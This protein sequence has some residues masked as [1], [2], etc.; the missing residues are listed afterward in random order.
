MELTDIDSTDEE[1]EIRILHLRNSLTAAESRI[2]TLEGELEEVNERRK[3]LEASRMRNMRCF[4][5]IKDKTE[6]ISE[7]LT[8]IAEAIKEIDSIEGPDES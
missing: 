7:A 3:Y 1:Q 6:I 5:T 8:Q 2:A 4:K